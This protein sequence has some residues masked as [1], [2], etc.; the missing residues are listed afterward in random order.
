MNELKNLKLNFLFKITFYILLY[1]NKHSYKFTTFKLIVFI[2]YL[3]LTMFQRFAHSTIPKS[4]YKN[5][6]ITSIT[7]TIPSCFHLYFGK[8][9]TSSNLENKTISQARS[10]AHSTIEFES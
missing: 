9:T 4:D 10:C 1:I 6:A 5:K 3:H 2:I 7:K 8:F